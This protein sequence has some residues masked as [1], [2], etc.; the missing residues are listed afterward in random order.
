MVQD[1]ENRQAIREAEFCAFKSLFPLLPARVLEMGAGQGFQARLLRD[2][3]YDIYASDLRTGYEFQAKDIPFTVC[4]GRHFPYTNSQFDVVY[5]SN[6]L[7]QVLDREQFHHE[8]SRVLTPQGQW[9]VVVPTSTWRFWTLV[10]FYLR[11]PI[12]IC[13]RMSRFKSEV[14]GGARPGQAR[15]FFSRLLPAEGQRG[16]ALTEIF[17][18][19]HRE[20]LRFFQQLG[21]R[22]VRVEPV[23]L[24]YTGCNL[25]GAHLPIQAR[26]L[27]ARFLGSAC[28]VYVL[29]RDHGKTI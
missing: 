23:R 16:N 11:L 10:T 7:D 21:W 2:A 28:R 20:R 17:T 4:D 22:A 5:I 15:G 26:R 24:F 8:V 3:G 25:F 27:L 14:P 6:V 13:R 19:Q 29:E 1:R 12:A 9:I 18:F